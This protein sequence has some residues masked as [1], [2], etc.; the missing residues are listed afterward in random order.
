MLLSGKF[1]FSFL[2]LKLVATIFPNCNPLS[3][4]TTTFVSIGK[5]KPTGEK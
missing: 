4:S 3:V 2:I 1:R 5:S